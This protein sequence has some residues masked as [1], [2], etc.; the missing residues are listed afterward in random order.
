MMQI[1]PD[2]TKHFLP[3]LF[4]P[5]VGLLLW[6]TSSCHILQHLTNLFGNH[7]GDQTWRRS[8]GYNGFGEVVN[9]LCKTARHSRVGFP[10][11]WC[12][13]SSTNHTH[14]TGVFVLH[15]LNNIYKIITPRNTDYYS[16]MKLHKQI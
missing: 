12:C 3:I 15:T 16:T 13:E 5:I 9:V 6:R 1:G 2:F 4:L 7:H 14:K 8:P 11:V 10:M